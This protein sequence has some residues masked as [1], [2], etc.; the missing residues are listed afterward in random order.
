MKSTP[1]THSWMTCCWLWAFRP[2]STVNFPFRN[3][4][5]STDT[6]F[7]KIFSIFSKKK[8]MFKMNL[9]T[10]N[11]SLHDANRMRV[12]VLYADLHDADVHPFQTAWGWK[13]GDLPAACGS[14]D[15]SSRCFSC[16]CCSD[17]CPSDTT[18]DTDGQTTPLI[19]INTT[20]RDFFLCLNW[21]LK[22]LNTYR[23]CRL[24]T[25]VAEALITDEL[26]TSHGSIKGTICRTE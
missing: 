7:L 12:S 17:S 22:L 5:N 10:C 4:E 25:D 14:W 19:N 2:Y 24:V 9:T 23:W 21:T 3:V 8:K 15:C 1:V 16:S 26:I 20:V 13:S 6:P 18:L 11:S